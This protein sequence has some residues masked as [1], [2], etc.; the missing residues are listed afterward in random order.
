VL[1]AIEDE[2]RA[3]REVI[4]AGIGA[5]RPGVEVASVGLEGLEGE[6]ARLDPRVV[7][8]SGPEP[9]GAGTRR[10]AW[11]ELPLEPIRP[12]KVRRGGRRSEAADPTLEA[13]LA[14]VDEAEQLSGLPVSETKI[15]SM[16]A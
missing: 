9:A 14:V 2:Y 4:A 12:M 8:C 6:L 11:V 5:L 16:L 3:Y 7:I 1:I 15:P 10:E 13:L